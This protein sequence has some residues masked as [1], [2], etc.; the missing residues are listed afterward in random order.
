MARFRMRGMDDFHAQLAP[1]IK[2]MQ[3]EQEQ[4][5]RQLEKERHQRSIMRQSHVSAMRSPFD[6]SVWPH[7][8][9]WWPH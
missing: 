6:R 4:F 1:V 2:Q 3:R 9:A 7:P 8:P 5:R